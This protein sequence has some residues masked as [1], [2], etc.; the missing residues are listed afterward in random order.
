MKKGQDLLHLSGIKVNWSFG[1]V[2]LLIVENNVQEFEELEW[3]IS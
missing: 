3:K 1:L 2:S